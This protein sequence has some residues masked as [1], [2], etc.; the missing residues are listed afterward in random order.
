MYLQH[1]WS[2][3]IKLWIIGTDK[4]Q[5]FF[6]HEWA[7]ISFHGPKQQEISSSFSSF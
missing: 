5:C 7:I 4:H 1:P 6:L 2:Y 3:S